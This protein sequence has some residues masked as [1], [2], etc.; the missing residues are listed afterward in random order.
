M[1][2]LGID[3][4]FGKNGSTML[5]YKNAFAIQKMSQKLRKSTTVLWGKFLA[6]LK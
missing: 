1:F 3:Q 6:H 5:R 2:I 4:N